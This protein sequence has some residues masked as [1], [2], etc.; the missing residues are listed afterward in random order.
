MHVARGH[1]INDR[2][3]NKTNMNPVWADSSKWLEGMTKDPPRPGCFGSLKNTN[4]VDFLKSHTRNPLPDKMA[5]D[6]SCRAKLRHVKSFY[7]LQAEKEMDKGVIYAE[8]DGKS[9]KITITTRDFAGSFNILLN[10][11]MVDFGKPINLSVNGSESQVK[12]APSVKVIEETT[13]ERGD[14]NFQFS[15]MVEVKV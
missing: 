1:A 8:K 12:A 14:V 13:K 10:G 5:W 9:N 2:M 3:A 11:K 6:L 7:W 15:V 4:A